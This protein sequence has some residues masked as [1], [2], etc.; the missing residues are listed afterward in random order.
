MGRGC[1]DYGPHSGL[2]AFQ[3]L[4]LGAPCPTEG[5]VVKKA[6]FRFGFSQYFASCNE[7]IG[8]EVGNWKPNFQFRGLKESGMGGSCG[9]LNYSAQ[10]LGASPGEIF[11]RSLRFTA[12]S[13]AKIGSRKSLARIRISPITPGGRTSDTRVPK[14]SGSDAPGFYVLYSR[15]VLFF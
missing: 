9:A 10:Q 5:H 14:S 6:V 2:P 15:D 13:R 11:G 8:S 4:P 1:R 3:T 7:K 12:L